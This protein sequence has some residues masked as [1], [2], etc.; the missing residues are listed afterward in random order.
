MTAMENG[1]NSVNLGSSANI[2][3]IYHDDI[4]RKQFI[5]NFTADSVMSL[6]RSVAIS[7]RTAIVILLW[8]SP[9]QGLFRAISFNVSAVTLLHV[10]G[11][12][13][14]CHTTDVIGKYIF[15]SF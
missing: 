9:V 15:N 3:N 8:I 13:F 7:V 2:Y 5:L 10:S 1:L 6:S 11:G 4:Y 12:V 14:Q